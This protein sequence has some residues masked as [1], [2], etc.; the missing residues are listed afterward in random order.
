MKADRP[1]ARP[2]FTYLLYRQPSIIVKTRIPMRFRRMKMN[3]GRS[4]QIAGRKKKIHGLR[5]F[6]R[7]FH[8]GSPLERFHHSL[9][10]YNGFFLRATNHEHEPRPFRQARYRSGSSSSNLATM[11]FC[12]AR[13]GS[14]RTIFPNVFALQFGC[15]VVVVP[16]FNCDQYKSLSIKYFRY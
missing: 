16:F 7:G 9:A 5:S 12:S 11:R 8:V 15:A 4:S 1:A 6:R 2:L 3:A 14:G 10:E 13:G